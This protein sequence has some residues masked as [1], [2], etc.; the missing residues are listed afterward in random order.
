MKKTMNISALNALETERLKEALKEE[1]RLTLDRYGPKYFA[2][3]EAVLENLKLFLEI[4]CKVNDLD[5]QT[6]TRAFFDT[7][8]RLEQ[9]TQEICGNMLAASKGHN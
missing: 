9:R 3:T 5:V 7:A 6:A 2:V 8:V 4:N 1:F